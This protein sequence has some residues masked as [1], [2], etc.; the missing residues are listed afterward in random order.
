MIIAPLQIRLDA[1][2]PSGNL[3]HVLSMMDQAAGSAPTPAHPGLTG[4]QAVAPAPD[5]G[6]SAAWC[7]DG[8]QV[9][10]AAV[11][12]KAIMFAEVWSP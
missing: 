1:H 8:A 11:T 10:R 3:S 12:D 7:T 4:R 5:T 6:A 2:S 9:C